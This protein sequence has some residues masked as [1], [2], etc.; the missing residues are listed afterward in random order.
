MAPGRPGALSEGT[1]AERRLAFLLCAPAVLVM[2]AVAA[3]PIIHG[4]SVGR[5]LVR[6]VSLI[7]YGI[8]TVVAAYSWYFAWSQ[9]SG[10]L[11]RMFG[12]DAAPLPAMKPAVLVA[13]AFSTVDAFRVFDNVFVL[14][15]GANDTATV[16]MLTYHN[17]FIG[18]DLGMSS[19]MSVLLLLSAASIAFVFIK[20]FGAAVP[21]GGERRNR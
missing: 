11:S 4:A 16:S 1:R 17:L 8:I 13:C 19:T 3:W 5:G 14:T 15:R 6:T 21:G 20:I 2:G 10:Y 12:P 18:L 9:E 7:P